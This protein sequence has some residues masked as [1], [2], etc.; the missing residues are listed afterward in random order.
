[1]VRAQ[2]QKPLPPMHG[3]A[4]EMDLD[5][6]P[7][8]KVTDDGAVALAV[9]GLEGIERLVGED[10]AKAEGVVRAVALEDGDVASVARPSSSG[11]RNK[12]RPGRR[13]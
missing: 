1:M 7:I 4:A 3:W 13:R 10:D 2:P 8:G 11:W 12:G 5:I 6:V 9:I